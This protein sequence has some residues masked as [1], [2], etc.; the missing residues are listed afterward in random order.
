MVNVTGLSH[1][2]ASSAN[3]ACE[4]R[5]LTFTAPTIIIIDMRM[6]MPRLKPIM[7]FTIHGGS[8]SRKIVRYDSRAVNITIIAT[9]D[10]SMAKTPAIMEPVRSDLHRQ[11]LFNIGLA[12]LPL[13]LLVFYEKLSCKSEIR[14]GHIS[15]WENVCQ[16]TE[17][18]RKQAN[19]K[20]TKAKWVG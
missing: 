5:A 18:N 8:Q 16:A 9:I 7:I 10:I 17:T 11:K 3:C 1:T 6:V 4:S 19:S 15:R 13:S 20:T 2:R 14:I 12:I